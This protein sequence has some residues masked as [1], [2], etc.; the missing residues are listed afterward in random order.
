MK[1]LHHYCS[2]CLPLARAVL[3]LFLCGVVCAAS[4]EARAFTYMYASGPTGQTTITHPLGF[5]SAGGVIDLGIGIDPSSPHAADMDISVRNAIDTWNALDPTTSNLEFGTSNNVPS[6][7][8]DFESVVLHELGHVLGLNHPNLGSQTGVSGSDKDHT[9]SDK[10]TNGG[11]DLDAG[12]DGVIGSRDDLRGDDVNLNWFKKADNNPFV[13]NSTGIYDTTTY[14]PFLADL[15]EGDTYSANASRAVGS[16]EG[17][18]NSES[19]MQQGMTTDEAQRTLTEDDVA[20]IRVGMTG[21]DKLQGTADDYTINLI[22]DGLDG[23][24]DVVLD[25]DNMT[26]FASSTGIGLYAGSGHQT[27][28]STGVHFNTGWNWFFNDV[29]RQNV[30]MGDADGDGDVDIEDALSSFTNFTGPD[31]TGKT[32][33]DGDVESHPNGD[34]DVDVSDIVLI[35]SKFT[36]SLDGSGG[37]QTPAAVGDLSIPDLIYDAATG[38]VT[39]DVDGSGIIGYV[40][41]NGTSDFSFG[42][43]LQILAGVKTSVLNE[44]SEAAFA[45]SVGA[46]SIGNVFPTGMNLAALTAYLTV[47]QVST[48]LGAPV[49]PFDLVVIGGTPAVPEPSTYAMAVLGLLALGLLSRQCRGTRR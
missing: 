35:F 45:S 29:R 32:R 14:S 3:G 28:C 16:L 39:L 2:F 42:N 25:F 18:A 41:K 9:H 26:S 17:F 46:N 11:F 38:E 5:S 30:T 40:L 21:H 10:G 12:A 43:H 23:D 22:Y 37:L 8:Y 48:S 1:N 44:L 34:G 15:P 27:M 33:A 6:G 20:G 36:G 49:V 7:F 47:N 24:A 19:V 13:V 4:R 31:V